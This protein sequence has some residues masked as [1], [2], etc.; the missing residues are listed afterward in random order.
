MRAWSVPARARRG[1]PRRLALVLY[2]IL[3]THRRPWDL[4]N[5]LEVIG[6]QTVPPDHLLVVDNAPTSENEEACRGQEYGIEEIEYVASPTNVGPAGGFALG[7][8]RVLEGADDNDWVVLFD[9]DD[10]PYR[11]DLLEVM[12]RFANETRRGDPHT[13]GVGMFGSILSRVLK[14]PDRPDRTDL[15]GPVPVDAIGNGRIP[16]YLVGAVRRGGTYDPRLFFGLEELEF[17]LRLKSAGYTQY[18]NGDVW[19]E[20]IRSHGSPDRAPR[21]TLQRSGWRSYYAVRN[22]IWIQRSHGWLLGALFTTFVV[23]LG[24]PLANLPI[25]PMA[26]TAHLKL[27][28]RAAIDGWTGRLGKTIEPDV[29]TRATR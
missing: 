10:P 1:I 23:A 25:D 12:L 14:R 7:M 11:G 24:K 29:D 6:R 9:D 15:A 19:S 26:A 20:W 2:G 22:M 16:V 13:G 28:L 5:S 17:G 8:Q 18:A 4:R 27:N 3:V 21:A